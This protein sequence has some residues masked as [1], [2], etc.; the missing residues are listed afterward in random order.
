MEAGAQVWPVRIRYLNA[1]G[2]HCPEAAY[3]GAM[4][5]GE[6]LLKVLRLKGLRAQVEFLPPIDSQG[7]AR[8]DLARA[9]EAA[10]G[11]AFSATSASAGRAVGWGER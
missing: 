1:D 8:R 7:M 3:F 10:I 9:T 2:S 11:A 5:L 6:S 4:T